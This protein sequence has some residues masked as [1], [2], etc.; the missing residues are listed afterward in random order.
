MLADRGVPLIRVAIGH[1]EL[2]VREHR[3]EL[4]KVE[5]PRIVGKGVEFW[6][7]TV[8]RGP[9]RVGVWIRISIK[10]ASHAVPHQRQRVLQRGRAGLLKTD[11]EH[12]GL[13]WAVAQAPQVE[14]R[15]VLEGLTRIMMLS[16]AHFL[17]YPFYVVT[18][19]GLP[20]SYDAA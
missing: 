12:F 14:R 20:G 15:A 11:T 10:D 13:W 18:T 5:R 1:N 3:V 4:A 7:Q 2:S 17:G 19:L 6:Q 9:Q 16:A 8:R